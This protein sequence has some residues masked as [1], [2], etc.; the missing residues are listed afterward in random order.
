MDGVLESFMRRETRRVHPDFSDVQL[1]GRFYR[2]DKRLRGGKVEIHSLDQAYLGKGVLHER[3]QG[4]AADSVSPAKPQHNYLDLLIDKHETELSE[5]TAGIDFRQAMRPRP[6]P[7]HAF[8]KKL[9][10]RLGRKGQLTAL[11]AAEL[12]T[13]QKFHTRHPGLNP[14]MLTQAVE[15]AREKTVPCILYEL[16]KLAPTTET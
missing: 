8:A 13:L 1:H 12:E 14:T 11:R 5:R 4:E 2:V 10:E 3:Q 15:K 16:R 7:F 9:A 6:W